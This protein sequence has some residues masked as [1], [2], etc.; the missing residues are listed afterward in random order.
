MP[1][2]HR[3]IASIA[4]VA[5]VFATAIALGAAAAPEVLTFGP[6]A[7]ATIKAGSPSTNFGGTARL[8]I[9][10]KPLK[11][12]LMTFEVSGIGSR[13]VTQATLR[14]FC[15]NGSPFGGRFHR[16]PD[17]SWGERS[18]TWQNAPA[19]DATPIATLGPVAANTWYEVDVTPLVVADGTFSLRTTSTSGNDAIYASKEAG[20]ATA[21][22]LVVTL[23]TPP[24]T[25]PPS[26]AITMPAD[27]ATVSGTTG[28]DVTGSDDVGVASVDLAIDD[29]VQQTVT[30]EPYTFAWDTSSTSN[31]SHVL[32]AIAHDA[33]GHATTS[34][35]VTVTV[36]NTP[37]TTPPSAPSGLSASAPA[38]DRVDLTWTAA[39]DDVAVT[40]YRIFRDGAQVAATG[41]TFYV[42]AT[43]LPGRTYSYSVVAVDAAGNSSAPSDEAT[44]TTPSAAAGVSFAA[45]G[46]HGANVNTEASLAALDRSGVD[47]YL[48]LGDLDYDQVDSDSAWCDFVKARLPTLGP[49]F[50]FQLVSGNHEEQNGPDGYVL[51][52]AACLPDRMSSTGTYAAEYRFDYPPSSPLV[53]VIMIG[54]DLTIGN[55]S[56]DYVRGT[57]RYTWLS[58][59]IDGAR[60]AG[61]PWVVVG[62]HKVC[63]TT[64]GKTCEIGTD[65][66]NLL[67]QKRVD[68]VLQGH[69]HA[70]ERS[71]QL[72]LDPAGCPEVPAGSFDADCVVD[73]G[74][75]GLYAKGA[76][77]VFVIDGTFGRESLDQPRSG[78]PEAGYFA[79]MNGTTFGFT[80]YMVTEDR[81]EA[82]FVKSVGSFTDGFD[83][84][85]A[86]SSSPDPNP[87]VASNV[88][89]GT[90]E[91]VPADVTLAGT[92]LERCELTFSV[93]SGPSHGSLSPIG[94][95]A[96]TPGS[97]NADTATM[98]YTPAPNHEGQDSFTYRVS[99]GGNDSDV[100]TAS[101]TVAATNDPPSA[102][103]A[104]VVTEVGTPLAV[105]VT[106]TDVESCEL[107]FTVLSSPAHGSLGPLVAEPCSA[108]TPNADAASVTYTPAA[109]YEGPDSF[110]FRVED[111]TAS[112]TAATASVT[113]GGGPTSIVLRGASS[114][115]NLT[116]T[117]LTIA[118]PAGVE[119]GDVLV[120]GVSV[121][122]SP[123][124]TPPAGWTLVRSDQNPT[125][126]KQAVFVRVAVAAEPADYTWT[127]SVPQAA[128]GG[129]L[130]YSGVD[131]ANP[132][133]GHSGFVATTASTT[134]TA[135]SLTTT[136]GG[137][138]VAAFY[139]ITGATT[140]TPPVGTTERWDLASS[141]GTYR[142]TAEA[143]ETIRPVA[144]PTGDLVAAAANSGRSIGQLVALRP[145]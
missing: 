93:I 68:V 114:S 96:C 30:T 55:V 62:M 9:D 90:T 113:V 76:G 99:D 53:R 117:T 20:A 123:A 143:A 14:L 107:T 84:E 102:I 134:I 89:A 72:A 116:A 75:D 133:D 135:P 16:V 28:V 77:T 125:I 88:T 56:Y 97:P 19:A 17:T 48:A 27:G 41:S 13:T 140:V 109:G 18:V 54:A 38:A 82:R 111:G 104:S 42:D 44:V 39:T 91:D 70:Y 79:S 98:T 4:V 87:P 10:N 64:G 1:V 142:I 58:D 35:P 86:A 67:I 69:E 74:Q 101:I 108:G 47:F 65:L 40:G 137:V 118:R 92:D 6:A 94:G 46:D 33:A 105:R 24:D 51:N 141:A 130:A 36:D 50:P 73:D 12:S 145:A 106:G 110:T 81:L 34:S 8:E 78:D 32:T 103:G 5:S 45:A 127:F 49:S 129:I 26:A 23:A 2:A 63:L 59:A 37:D 21:P 85:V 61:I 131:T 43:V 57:A 128:A 71:K 3:R 7:D 100:A 122:G 144:A 115:V 66:M 132:V 15:V 31:G 124:I 121:R 136:V 25:T 80:R 60:A 138:A 22:R 95:R 52:H 29:V 83:I 11:H 126:M 139:G 112:S 120:T 119:S